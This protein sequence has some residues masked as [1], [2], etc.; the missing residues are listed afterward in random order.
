MKTTPSSM[1]VNILWCLVQLIP[2]L[3]MYIKLKT[4]RQ[5][6][7]METFMSLNKQEVG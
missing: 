7:F 5:E 6:V 1:F 3:E 2:I 4:Q